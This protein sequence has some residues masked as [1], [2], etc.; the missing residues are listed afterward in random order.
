MA[1]FLVTCNGRGQRLF[2]EVGHDTA[3]IRKRLDDPPLAGFFAAGEFGPLSGSNFI[4]SQ[5]VVA[6]L[7]G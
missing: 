1:T 3:I 5:A 4:H 7:F 6:T 2:G